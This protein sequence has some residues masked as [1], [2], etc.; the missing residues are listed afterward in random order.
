MGRQWQ[1]RE[2]CNWIVLEGWTAQDIPSFGV[3]SESVIEV[4]L[5]WDL[6]TVKAI[7][8]D[9]HYSHWDWIMS[10]KSVFPLIYS[11]FFLCHLCVYSVSPSV[12]YLVL[13][14]H[15]LK[16]IQEHSFSPTKSNRR[17]LCIWIKAAAFFFLNMWKQGRKLVVCFSVKKMQVVKF[18]QIHQNKCITHAK[19]NYFGVMLKHTFKTI[20]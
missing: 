3:T 9:S 18:S 13:F 10:Y 8:Y 19:K 15:P 11:F 7:I 17:F 16:A 20:M 4:E 1:I 12:L 2:P 14:L 5:G 6:G